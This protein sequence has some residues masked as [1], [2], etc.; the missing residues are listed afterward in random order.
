VELHRGVKGLVELDFWNA[1]DAG[2]RSTVDRSL[3]VVLLLTF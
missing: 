2:G 1:R 3:S